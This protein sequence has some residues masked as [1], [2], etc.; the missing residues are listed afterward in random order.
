MITQ[1]SSSTPR[2]ARRWTTPWRNMLSPSS[3]LTLYER[4]EQAIMLV[5]IGLIM[6]VTV[7][8]TAHLVV[9]VWHLLSSS[10]VDPTDQRV[11]QT[12]FGAVFTVLIA[13]LAIARKFILLDLQTIA[14]MDVLSLAA[15]VL[16]LGIVY[17]LVRDQDARIRQQD[18]SLRKDVPDAQ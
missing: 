1:P 13:L 5:L 15:A 6:A 16:A 2:T 7:S 17:W 14:P 10:A 12:V 4:F 3:G 8:A 9:A 18:A 11:F